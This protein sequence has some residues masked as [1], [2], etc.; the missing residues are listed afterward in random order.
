MNSLSAEV[1]QRLPSLKDKFLVDFV[2][3]IDVAKEQ[4]RF[5]NERRSFFNRLVDGFTGKGQARQQHI[6]EQMLNG[7]EG[8]LRWLSEMTEQLTFSNY[9]L[10]KTTRELTSLKNNVTLLADFSADTREMLNSLAVSI[11]GRLDSLE[12]RLN[13]V[14]MRQRAFQHIDILISQWRA[15]HLNCLSIAEQ[16]YAIINELAWGDCGDFL[17]KCTSHL[18]RKK[19]LQ[20]LQT[21]LVNYVCDITGGTPQQRYS[22]EVLLLSTSQGHSLL[23]E[24]F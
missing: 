11:N 20:Y 17:R 2:N 16:C 6:N 5:Q 10:E 9:A 22:S 15:E 14:D 24:D 3:G 18:D 23:V 19:L 13:D 12:I 21:E 7:L 8:C 1:V 4:V